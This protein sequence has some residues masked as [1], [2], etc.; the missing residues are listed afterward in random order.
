MQSV[1]MLV[2]AVDWKASEKYPVSSRLNE[3][4]ADGNTIYVQKLTILHLYAN[5]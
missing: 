5:K 2:E 1:L 3:N 4:I